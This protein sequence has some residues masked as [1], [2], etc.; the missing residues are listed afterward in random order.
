MR[1]RLKLIWDNDYDRTASVITVI[2]PEPEPEK[3]KKI[4]FYR[5]PEGR[6]MQS[7]RGTRGVKVSGLRLRPEHRKGF[8]VVV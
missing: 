6:Q 1:T 2:E 7:E 3:P 4:H 8:K 5:T